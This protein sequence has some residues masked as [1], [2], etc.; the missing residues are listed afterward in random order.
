VGGALRLNDCLASRDPCRDCNAYPIRFA[1][2]LAPDNIARLVRIYD[3][4]GLD[5]IA[6]AY[7]ISRLPLP[8]NLPLH[9]FNFF[10]TRPWNPCLSSCARLV[11][12]M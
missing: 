6:W 12:A 7:L 1:D 8:F 4:L 3:S 5:Y 9:N 10:I 2:C 11:Y